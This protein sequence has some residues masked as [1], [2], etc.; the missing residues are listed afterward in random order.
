MGRTRG[1]GRGGAGVGGA[2]AALGVGRPAICA[3]ISAACQDLLD[4]AGSALYNPVVLPLGRRATAL[5]QEQIWS[6]TVYQA[7]GAVGGRRVHIWDSWQ[8]ELRGGSISAPRP[9]RRACS[10]PAAQRRRRRRC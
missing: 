9:R 6:R 3:L 5:T 7:A 1:D 4:P 10:W 8:L 2:G